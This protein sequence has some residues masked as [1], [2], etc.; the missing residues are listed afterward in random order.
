MLATSILTTTLALF[1]PS[2]VGPSSDPLPATVTDATLSI[3]D[4]DVTVSD[5]GEGHFESELR[6]IGTATANGV[7]VTSQLALNCVVDNGDE[8]LHCTGGVRLGNM[9]APIEL[10]FHEGMAR[11]ELGQGFVQTHGAIWDLWIEELLVDA[12][13]QADANGNKILGWDWSAVIIVN[14]RIYWVESDWLWIIDG[15]ILNPPQW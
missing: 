8:F 6:A 13:P 3:A 12:V 15:I 10:Q 7:S 2:L 5:L 1:A 11:Y 4:V 9:D 14:G